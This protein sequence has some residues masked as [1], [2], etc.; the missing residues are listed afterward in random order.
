MIASEAERYLHDAK[1]AV[2]RVARFT[3]DRTFDDYVADDMLRSAVERQFEIIGEALASVRR[4]DPVLAGSV[5][6]LQRIIAFRNVLIHA[7]AT[8]DDRLVWGVVE[9]DLE[10][11][12][13]TLAELLRA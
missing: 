6:D 11:L 12:R 5:P 9:R 4:I 7:Y 8:V 1:V 2:E 3:A 13:T 10:I